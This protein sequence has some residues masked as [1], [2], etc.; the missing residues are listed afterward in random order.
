MKNKY[1][2]LNFDIIEKAVATDA[3]AMHKVIAHYGGYI[4]YFA[5]DNYVFSEEIKA[6]LMKA[7]LKFNIDR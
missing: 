6:T 4:G 3:Q 5:K 7:V 1:K 2:L